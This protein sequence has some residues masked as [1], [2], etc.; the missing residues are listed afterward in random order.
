[1]AQ[2]Y[3]AQPR[4]NVKA[5]PLA[6]QQVVALDHQ[7]RGIVRTAK[8]VRFV[9]QALPDEVITLLPQGKYDAE[10]ITMEQASPLRVKP[11]C[12]FYQHCGGCDFQHLE[13]S[14]QRQHKQ[15]TVAQMLRKFADVEAQQWL[16][17]LTADAW[18]YR[19]RARLAVHYDRKRHQLKLGFRAAK[20]KQITAITS[21]LTLA[22]PLNA[23]LQPLQQ[24]LPTLALVRTLGHVELVE[25]E[26]QPL[27]LLRV[28]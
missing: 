5:E 27:L 11:P 6:H 19:R 20:S 24:L 25:L 8:G 4:K 23:L 10:L 2:F 26:P 22:K 21:C 3:K 18:H 14:A 16:E 7:G 28:N 12:E 1:M 17:P 15:T 13:L 9:P